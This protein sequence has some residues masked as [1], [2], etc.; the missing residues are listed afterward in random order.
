M[1]NIELNKN[2]YLDVS[3]S[4]P[5]EVKTLAFEDKG[6]LCNKYGGPVMIISYEIFKMNGYIRNVVDTFEPKR[7]NRIIAK[8]PEEFNIPSWSLVRFDKPRYSMGGW[9]IM[10]FVF[11]DIVGLSIS[12]SMYDLYLKHKNI[13]VNILS[14][15]IFEIIIDDVDPVGEIV[16]TWKIE[17]AKIISFNFGLCDMK[18]ESISEIE[19]EI[20][21]LNCILL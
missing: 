20:L 15:P 2:Y 9:E 21:P 13:D 8:F 16:N 14:Q 3:S 6:V 11:I 4:T 5:I 10:K 17:V 18:D 7:N 19:L 1:K 12:K